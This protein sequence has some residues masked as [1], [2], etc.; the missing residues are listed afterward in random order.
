MVPE[1]VPES[2]GVTQLLR[3]FW[4]RQQG[5]MGWTAEV[6]ALQA[7][8]E[9]QDTWAAQVVEL[10]ERVDTEEK[11]LR[12]AWRGAR[13][14]SRA[15]FVTSGL[16][17]VTQAKSIDAAL[18]N[19]REW[20]G[21][22]VRPNELRFNVITGV[23]SRIP[24]LAANISKIQ[25]QRHAAAKSEKEAIQAPLKTLLRQAEDCP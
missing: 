22:D 7:A 23:T 9:C 14:Y 3:D 19:R 15:I 4:Q 16:M 10:S 17:Y 12:K 2:H 13:R 5:H 21:E 11:A 8:P 6:E 24:Y 25:R 18:D 1:L 20:R